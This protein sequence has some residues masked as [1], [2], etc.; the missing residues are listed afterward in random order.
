[1]DLAGYLMFIGQIADALSMPVAGILSD[2]S[3]GCYNMG[4]RKWW[5]AIG[6]YHSG[7]MLNEPREYLPTGMRSKVLVVSRFNFSSTWT[8]A[9][10][11]Y[12]MAY[13][14][15]VNEDEW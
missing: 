2:R 9:L 15:S 10:Y 8:A 12:M 4:K 14:L 6:R 7:K 11:F 13:R 1:M 5:H 3:N